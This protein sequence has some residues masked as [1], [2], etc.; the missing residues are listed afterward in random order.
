LGRVILNGEGQKMATTEKC[1]NGT[2][3][4]GGEGEVKR[5]A[6]GKAAEAE[7]KVESFLSDL[8][9]AGG[10]E[11]KLAE[12]LEEMKMPSVV[13]QVRLGPT[14]PD[15]ETPSFDALL[16]V[17]P[18]LCAC[19]N[20]EKLSKASA[21]CKELKLDDP[22]VVQARQAYE[23]SMN[24]D[25]DLGA[26]ALSTAAVMHLGMEIGRRVRQREEEEKVEPPPNQALILRLRV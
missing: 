12:L 1:E 20:A 3:P 10:A 6:S 21:V 16:A 18:Q 9:Q 25:T 22:I 7:K 11:E 2:G 14:M 5:A 26:A 24:N 17:L 13:A 19:G 23:V 4:S 15:G 8:K